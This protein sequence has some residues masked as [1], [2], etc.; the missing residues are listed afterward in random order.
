MVYLREYSMWCLMV[1]PFGGSIVGTRQDM[2]EAM[3]L[4]AAGK[5][6]PTYQRRP[7]EDLN[8]IFDEMRKGEIDGRVVIEY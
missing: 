6:K 5:V 8:E 3:E 1:S 4:Y 2:I 7:L